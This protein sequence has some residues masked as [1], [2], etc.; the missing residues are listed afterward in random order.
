MSKAIGKTPI[1]N[2]NSPGRTVN[3]DTEKDMTVREAILASLPTV[4][5]GM[6]IAELKEQVA[7]AVPNLLFPAGAKLGWWL[8][9]VQLDLEAKRL[10]DGSPTKPLRLYRV[11]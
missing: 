4:A 1:E 2:L 3:V 11:V 10:I 6:T 9:G 5:P 8:K 7:A